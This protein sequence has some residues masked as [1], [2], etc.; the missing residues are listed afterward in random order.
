LQEEK[1]EEEAAAALF[2]SSAGESELFLL[3]NLLQGVRCANRGE[4]FVG[5]D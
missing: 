4:A 3:S 1:D 5:R 2:L